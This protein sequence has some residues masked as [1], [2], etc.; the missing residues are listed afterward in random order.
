MRRGFF[1]SWLIYH[2]DW[3]EQKR[4]TVELARPISS[5]NPPPS[6]RD[7]ECNRDHD[8]DIDV[9]A[10]ITEGGGEGAGDATHHQI[11]LGAGIGFASGESSPDLL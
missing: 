2:C 6:D 9:W 5:I 11:T 3:E 8:R 10:S 7:R 1:S 4:K